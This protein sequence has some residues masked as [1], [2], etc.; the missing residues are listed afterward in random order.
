MSKRVLLVDDSKVI[1]AAAQMALKDMQTRNEIEVQTYTNPAELLDKLLNGQETFDLLISDVNMPQ[2]NGLDLAQTLKNNE[3]YRTK[4]ILIMT[5]E[6]SVEMKA[7]GKSIGVTGWLVKPFN[8]KKLTG[9][10]SM[11]LGL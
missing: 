2:L 9:A 10:I 7:K 8:N 1:L 5:T 3:Q 4:P 11:I 6:S